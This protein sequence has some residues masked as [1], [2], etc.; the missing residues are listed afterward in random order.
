MEMKA[1]NEKIGTITTRLACLAACLLV[2]LVP[3]SNI[4]RASAHTDG[5]NTS[6]PAAVRLPIHSLDV[7]HGAVGHDPPES[8]V[9]TEKPTKTNLAAGR[10][11]G[12]LS[13]QGLS[14][15]ET[16]RYRL[17]PGAAM[18]ESTL[19][20]LPSVSM[21]VA[22]AQDATLS[23]LAV[24]ADGTAVAVTPAFSSEI[25]NYT[26]RVNAATI[27][28]EATA[29]RPGARIVSIAIGSASAPPNPDD[30]LLS[31]AFNLTECEV[32]VG[33][34]ARTTPG[35]PYAPDFT[36]TIVSKPMEADSLAPN[37]APPGDYVPLSNIV[38]F[39]SNDFREEDGVL[40]GRVE[41]PVITT[42]NSDV[43]VDDAGLNPWG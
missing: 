1:T 18:G 37:G 25:T 12:S 5:D 7:T 42:I 28:L 16:Q 31:A 22:P 4:G 24:T 6:N 32:L 20:G 3:L 39:H 35:V 17:M 2:I 8:Q 30:N 19:S 23:S 41:V 10:H 33:L 36:V 11:A 13:F 14:P 21:Q 27:N 38:E 43:A 26:A 34:E 15:P 29:T 40:V 9:L